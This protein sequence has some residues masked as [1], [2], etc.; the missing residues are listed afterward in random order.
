MRSTLIL[1]AVTVALVS[2][3]VAHTGVGQTST[4]SSGIAH[5]F[6]GADHIITM[7]AV[8]LWAVLAGR[9]AILV[10]PITFILA[11]LAGFAAAVVG[12]LIPFVE[13]F[14]WSSVIVMGILVAL[15]VKA[16]LWVGAVVVGLF[17]F[18]HG[19]VHGT[20]AP[21]ASLVPYT[22]GF[23]FATGALH[24]VGIALGLI[25][26]NSFR[27]LTLRARGVAAVLSG[28]ALIRG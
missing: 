4:F 12:L 23:A 21:A 22:L 7:V 15:S 11:M 18:F 9:R 20:E 17:A 26:E 16:P 28:I 1:V 5:P 2:P 10:W 27:K 24:A 6:Q 13:P 3:A 14:I 19:H 8:G 25:A